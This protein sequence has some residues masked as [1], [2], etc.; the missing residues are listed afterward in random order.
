MITKV[1]NERS[2]KM[3]SIKDSFERIYKDDDALT[4][5]LILLIL[6]VLVALPFVNFDFKASDPT[7]NLSS[8]LI[9]Y[10]IAIIFGIIF[11]GYLL[12][13]MNNTINAREQIL[14]YFN[15]EVI[16][17][18]FKAI[19]VSLVAAI[20]NIGISLI[21]SIIPIIGSIAGSILGG[22]IVIIMTLNYS[23][24]FQYSDAFNFEK[25]KELMSPIFVPFLL[26]FFKLLLVMLFI[27]IPLIFLSVFL[28]KNSLFIAIMIMIYFSIIL[29]LIYYENLAQIYTE[30]S[31]ECP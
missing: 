7:S 6:S 29:Q 19:P 14:P 18:G 1:Q 11:Y 12:T 22:L 31:Y 16:K 20:I 24:D 3:A 8:M 13:M 17:V 9:F 10:P 28:F 5:H 15:M 23:K 4:K 26:L 30:I 21:L 27:G 25:T 2:L